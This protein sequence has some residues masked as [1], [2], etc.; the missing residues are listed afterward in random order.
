M[1]FYKVQ[2]GETLS[3]I[4]AQ[5]CGFVDV[6]TVFE[7][8]KNKSLFSGVGEPRRSCPRAGSQAASVMGF[9]PV[10]S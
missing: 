9:P 8:E 7:H 1:P 6:T 4:V 2:Q 10:A 3:A 5:Q